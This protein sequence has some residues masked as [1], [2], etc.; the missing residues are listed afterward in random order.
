[1]ERLHPSFLKIDNDHF[2]ES[3]S[4]LPQNIKKGLEYWTNT[5]ACEIGPI[6]HN[7][8]P[9]IIAAL[10]EL[11]DAYAEGMP[12][13]GKAAED[14]RGMVTGRKFTILKLPK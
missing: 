11:A 2:L 6:D 12:G 4:E 13:S 7:E 14:V 10:R 5:L 8:A 9:L 1:M 3:V